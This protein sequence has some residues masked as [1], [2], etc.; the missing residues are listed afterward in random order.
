MIQPTQVDRA[1]AAAADD[2]HLAPGRMMCNRISVVDDFASP[3][4]EILGQ[5]LEGKRQRLVAIATSPASWRP[6]GPVSVG[7]AATVLLESWYRGTRLL[8]GGTASQPWRFLD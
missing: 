5:A 7:R 3:L 1:G 6:D 2:G 4:R 8:L